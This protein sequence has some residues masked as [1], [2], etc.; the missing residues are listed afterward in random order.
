MTFEKW[1]ETKG[2]IK[3]NFKVEDEGQEHLEDE[4]GIDIEFIVF[5][6]PQG[7]FRLEHV[8]KP[9]VLDRKTNYSKRIGSETNVN[10]IY[11]EEEKTT[12]LLA[13]KWDEDEEEWKEVENANFL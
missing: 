11:S 4:G 6:S 2:T 12:K 1:K 3:D 10:Y 9:V 7:L 13:Y 8:S 5:H